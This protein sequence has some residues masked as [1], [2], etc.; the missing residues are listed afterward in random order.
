MPPG[1]A[2]ANIV[3]PVTRGTRANGSRTPNGWGY[4]TYGHHPEPYAE[5][6]AASPVTECAE[7]HLANVAKTDM[8]YV[9]FYPLLRDKSAL[10]VTS[11][12]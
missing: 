8:T 10:S 5:S 12:R 1:R 7:C 4:F 9:Q 3:R 6:A 2:A 11:A